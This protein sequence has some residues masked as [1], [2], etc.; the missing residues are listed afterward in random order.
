M[1]EL[2]S[3]H[4]IRKVEIERLKQR[5]LDYFKSGNAFD[6]T[7][8]GMKKEFG[9]DLEELELLHYCLEILIDEGWIKKSMSIDHVEYDPGEKLDHGGIK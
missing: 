4:D 5:V 9:L 3:G 1:S 8:L 2:L 6:S 7:L